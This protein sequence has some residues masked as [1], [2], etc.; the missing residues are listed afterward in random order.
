M[1]GAMTFGPREEK[2]ATTGAVESVITSLFNILASGDLQ[3]KTC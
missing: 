1:S 2:E 3:R